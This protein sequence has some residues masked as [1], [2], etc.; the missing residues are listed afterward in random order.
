M[1]S[2]ISKKRLRRA[3][4]S[5]PRKPAPRSVPL[6]EERIKQLMKQAVREVLQEEREL[7]GAAPLSQP[8]ESES[9]P[10]VRVDPLQGKSREEL[11][12]LALQAE[13]SWKESEGTGTAVEIVRRL[14]DE[15]KHRP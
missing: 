2:T 1:A 13:G 4:A 9:R 5:K 15:W 11:R 3:P 14:R 7:Q 6:N 8:S 10:R 12:A